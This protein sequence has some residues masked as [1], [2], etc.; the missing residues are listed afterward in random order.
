[1]FYDGSDDSYL[2]VAHEVKAEITVRKSRFKAFI[3]PAASE[4]EAEQYLQALKKLYRDATHHCYAFM[5]N[6]EAG[7][8]VRLSDAGEPAGTAGRPILT[9]L[10][11]RKLSNVVCVVVRY[12]VGTK[13]GSGGLTRAYADAAKEALESAEFVERFV[14][15]TVRL[16]FPYELTGSVE[17]LIASFRV[18]ILQRDFGET[19]EITCAVRKN[20]VEDFLNRFRNITHGRGIVIH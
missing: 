13:L 1:M 5:I 17:G 9:A 3:K 2:T 18:S 14:T 4:G 10:E 6:N 11:G 15:D 16:R 12:F 8:T 20:K 19:N 7:R